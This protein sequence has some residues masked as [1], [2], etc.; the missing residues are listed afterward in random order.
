MIIIAKNLRNK[1]NEDMG[2]SFS[3]GA[4]PNDRE[5]PITQQINDDLPLQKSANEVIEVPQL[6]RIDQSQHEKDTKSLRSLTDNRKSMY[7]P[8][9][10]GLVPFIK[11]RKCAVHWDFK[12]SNFNHNQF[13]RK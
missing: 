6:R 7:N 5:D 9:G 1:E 13:Y 2:R 12:I 10:V 4:D 8:K 3:S 11:K